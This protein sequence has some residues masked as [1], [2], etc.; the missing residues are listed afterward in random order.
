MPTRL[1]KNFYEGFKEGILLNDLPRTFQHAIDFTRRLQV[2]YL[3]IDALCIIQDS[4]D[5]WLHEA[6]LM[7]SVYSNSRLNL[8]ATSSSDGHGGLYHAR[9]MLLTVPCIVTAS[10]E[11]FGKGTYQ[12]LDESAWRRRVN[13]GPL[14]H[15]AWVLQERLLTSRTAHFAYDQIWWECHCERA[16]EAF[17][18]GV[19]DST[20]SLEPDIIKTFSDLRPSDSIDSNEKW[21]QW[22]KAYTK[23]DLTKNSDK[24]VAIAGIATTVQ[25]MLDWPEADYLAGM[26]R[27]D[28][29]ADLLWRAAGV[30][31][32][33]QPY[34]APSW[35][36]ASVKG[37]IYFHSSEDRNVVRSS[38]AIRILKSN[39]TPVTGAMGPVKYGCLTIHGPL[40]RILLSEPDVSIV[41]YP[42]FE[43][44]TIGVTSLSGS[45]AFEDSLDDDRWYH[46]WQM[47]ERRTYFCRFMTTSTPH[48]EEAF[49]S[50]GLLFEP[51]GVQPGQYHRIGWLRMFLD[52]AQNIVVERSDLSSDEY[53]EMVDNG[54]YIF[55]VV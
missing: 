7:S 16:S 9:H 21:L 50:E 40:H 28:L 39:V 55:D 30:G 12:I 34:V 42:R 20:L 1:L 37:E 41:N 5:D 33:I 24:L 27:Q 52:D 14:N 25:R 3:W 46:E 32:K 18:D 47:R 38:L 48:L 4:Q 31:T 6:L 17:P 45:S 15:R 26:W 13:D 44:L 2:R 49:V 11:G 22:V 43:K 29:A 10:W 23:T 19:P 35:S 8:A 54:N 53:I 51:T 36:W